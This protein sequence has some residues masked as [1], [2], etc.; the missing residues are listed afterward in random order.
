MCL[1]IFG[2]F[3]EFAEKVFA[4]NKIVLEYCLCF[5]ALV[6]IFDTV[7]WINMGD[8]GISLLLVCFVISLSFLLYFKPHTIILKLPHLL[9]IRCYNLMLILEEYPRLIGVVLVILSQCS[10]LLLV[11][12]FVVIPFQEL[13]LLIELDLIVQIYHPRVVISCQHVDYLLAVFVL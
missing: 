11:F 13:P 8:Y 4:E 10:N 2:L 7:F 5:F 12:P 1:F 9:L 3:F 6:L